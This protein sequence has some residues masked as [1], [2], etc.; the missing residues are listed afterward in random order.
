MSD[1]CAH[2]SSHKSTVA[3]RATHWYIYLY[4]LH[5]VNGES[6]IPPPAAGHFL[7]SLAV[8]TCFFFALNYTALN[9]VAVRFRAKIIWRSSSSFFSLSLYLARVRS[10]HRDVTVLLYTRD[11]SPTGRSLH[12]PSTLPSRLLSHS[13]APSLPLLILF[14][15]LLSV[16]T[17]RCRFSEAAAAAAAGEV[18]AAPG[19]TLAGSITR[20]AATTPMSASQLSTCGSL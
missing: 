8:E 12:S 15:L 20:A 5:L 9:R 13:A 10:A 17:A 4:R 19:T 16:C 11:Y 1:A 7:C 3:P 14:H 2:S 6:I 18:L